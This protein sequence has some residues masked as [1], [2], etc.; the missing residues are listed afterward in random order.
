MAGGPQQTSM[1]VRRRNTR[2]EISPRAFLALYPDVT[3]TIM[4]AKLP[5]RK[6]NISMAVITRPAGGNPSYRSE[7]VLPRRDEIAPDARSLAGTRLGQAFQVTLIAPVDNLEANFKTV[8]TWNPMG[9]LAQHP[10]V[11][12]DNPVNIA[13]TRLGGHLLRDANLHAPCRDIDDM[14]VQMS[15]NSRQRNH[16]CRSAN[17]IPSIFSS[18]IHGSR[19][20]PLLGHR[21][22]M[23]SVSSCKEAW[24]SHAE[25]KSIRWF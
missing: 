8:R 24:R 4:A 20:S 19:L 10:I 7:L 15:A 12:A 5:Q 23:Q 16:L 11:V 21:P 22:R 1:A 13:D 18:F 14:P 2:N 17:F 3:L 25:K 9:N 6:T